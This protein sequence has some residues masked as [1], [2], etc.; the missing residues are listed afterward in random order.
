MFSYLAHQQIQQQQQAIQQQYAYQQQ[1]QQAMLQQQQAMFAQLQQPGVQPQTTESLPVQPTEASDNVEKKED[2]TAVQIQQ[3]PPVATQQQ[4]VMTTAYT[5][6]V[7]VNQPYMNQSAYVNPYMM[8]SGVVTTYP[9]APMP[10]Q[11]DANGNIVI[12]SGGFMGVFFWLIM[13]V[14]FLWIPCLGIVFLVIAFRVNSNTLTFNSQKRVLENTKTRSLT[15]QHVSTEEIPYDNIVEVECQVVPG[16]YINDMPVG[17][18]LLKLKNGST[19]D[20]GGSRQLPYAQ[21]FAQV[22]K[23]Q[24]IQQQS[25]AQV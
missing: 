19:T 18:V 2:V 5:Q 1:Q 3:Q 9:V 10:I 11:R 16:Y 12:E 6:P 22:V 25:A 8:N 23:E 4:P 21:Q 20:V 13:G 15:K 14:S 17:K 24:I 7:V